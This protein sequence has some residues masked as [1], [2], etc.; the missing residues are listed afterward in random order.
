M[1]PWGSRISDANER[2]SNSPPRTFTRP[3]HGRPLGEWDPLLV[4]AKNLGHSDTQMVERHYGHF[5]PSYQAEAV[6]K[7]APRFGFKSNVAALR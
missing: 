2:V 4:V 1:A 3:P 6:R 5:A 7:G